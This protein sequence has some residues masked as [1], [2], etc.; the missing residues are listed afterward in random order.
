LLTVRHRSYKCLRSFGWIL[1]LG[2]ERGLLSEHLAVVLE[3]LDV[4]VDG[5]LPILRKRAF[6]TNVIYSAT[7]VLIG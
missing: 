7:R 4:V 1:E 6:I 5:V 3:G 2:G